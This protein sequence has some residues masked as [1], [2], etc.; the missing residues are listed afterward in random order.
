MTTDP[1]LRL[2]A[3]AARVTGYPDRALGPVEDVAGPLRWLLEDAS[4]AA[5]LVELMEDKAIDAMTSGEARLE[6][7][8]WEAGVSLA[9]FRAGMPEATEPEEEDHEIQESVAAILNAM[10]GT[11]DP[12]DVAVAALLVS[13]LEGRHTILFRD[14]VREV[15]A[16]QARG[17]RQRRAGGPGMIGE[18]IE[19]ARGRPAVLTA[20]LEDEA[21]WA[22]RLSTMIVIGND[23][24]L[25]THDPWDNASLTGLGR[26]TRSERR[27]LLSAREAPRGWRAQGVPP[28]RKAGKQERQASTSKGK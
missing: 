7:I 14:A 19:A 1:D 8:L 12:S 23:M 18:I 13:R 2:A 21:A 10:L 24:G 5:G 6:A 11:D 17:Q 26:M 16:D 27:A 4:L 22:E 15:R 9:E 3:I 25:A 20:L 28:P